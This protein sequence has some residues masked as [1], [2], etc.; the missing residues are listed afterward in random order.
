MTVQPNSGDILEIVARSVTDS[1]SSPSPKTSTNFPTTPLSRR[2]FVMERTIS[3][4]VQISGILPVSLS[5]ITSGQ[6]KKM[7]CPNIAASAS[8]PPTP[9]PRTPMP[10]T[11]GVWESVPTKVSGNNQLSREIT[12]LARYSKFT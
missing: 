5:P 7:G 2:I 6:V 10:L 1:V 12:P 3:V 8:I 11:I 9:Q 4:A